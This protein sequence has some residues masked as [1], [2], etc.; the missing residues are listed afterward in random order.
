MFS[1]TGLA[2]AKNLV[3]I[4]ASHRAVTGCFFVWLS[5]FEMRQTEVSSNLHF[6]F[7]WR[8][9]PWTN[10]C[11]GLW[12]KVKTETHHLDRHSLA[13][14][15]QK[16]KFSFLFSFVHSWRNTLW[17]TWKDFYMFINSC[18]IS[19][20]SIKPKVICAS[21]PQ[22][23]HLLLFPLARTKI[24]L[25]IKKTTETQKWSRKIFSHRLSFLSVTKQTRD[26]IC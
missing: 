12:L 1:L 23:V 9:N 4:A 25:Y 18:Q 11:F 20:V 2:L 15:L 17:G 19:F 16:Q 10:V 26:Q 6:N 5:L 21:I 24:I 14:Y 3:S 8:S 13:V 22:F 7:L